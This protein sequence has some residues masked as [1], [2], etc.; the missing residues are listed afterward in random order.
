MIYP[1]STA[2]NQAA[3]AAE[4]LL[5]KAGLTPMGKLFRSTIPTAFSRR[6]LVRL[7]QSQQPF[8]NLPLESCWGL[9]SLRYCYGL[10]SVKHGALAVPQEAEP[11]GIVNDAGEAVTLTG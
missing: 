4:Y 10:V 3:E 6:P 5:T 9:G 8:L 7:R 11:T 2:W 1:W